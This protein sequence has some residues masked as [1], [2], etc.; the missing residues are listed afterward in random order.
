VSITPVRRV[1]RNRA[2]KG[3]QRGFYADIQAAGGQADVTTVIERRPVPAHVAD[4]LGVAPGTELLARARVMKA[5]GDVLQL[6]TS[7]FP[8][9][10]V[11]AIPVLGE[12]NTGAGGMY[13]RFEDAGHDLDIADIVDARS[14]SDDEVEALD[15]NEP[16]VV[17]IVRIARNRSTG[18]IL[19]VGDILSAPGRQQQVYQV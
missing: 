3:D 9:A 19:E 7:Y 6:A 8:D 15:L 10:V 4:E 13:Q 5:N 2:I 1:A 18:E 16:F 17:T 14:A 11:E 12:Q